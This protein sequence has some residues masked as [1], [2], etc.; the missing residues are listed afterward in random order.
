MKFLERIRA[1]FRGKHPEDDR[2]RRGRV[3]EEAAAKFLKNAGYQVLVMN[4][5]DRRDARR[6]I[7]IVCREPGGV[8]VFVEVKA[9]SEGDRKGG[10]FSVDRR[11]K[12]ALREAVTAYLRAL[13]PDSRHHH[14]FDIVEVVLVEGLPGDLIH[15]RAVTLFPERKR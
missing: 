5:R 12:A 3:G 8:L 2:A 10:Y 14:R 1:L 6:E 4:W 13:P 7:D 9:R 11:K 15:H